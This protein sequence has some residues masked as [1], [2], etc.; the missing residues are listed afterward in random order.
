[1]QDLMATLLK[2]FEGIIIQPLRDDPSG[3][4]QGLEPAG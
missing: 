4:L 2:I 3:P 1:M